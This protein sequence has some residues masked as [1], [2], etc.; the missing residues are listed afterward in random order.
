MTITKKLE[1]A[2]GSQPS[3]PT[4]ET[5]DV[6]SSLLKNLEIGAHIPR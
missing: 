2:A 3:T 4:R 6:S 5:G 1:L